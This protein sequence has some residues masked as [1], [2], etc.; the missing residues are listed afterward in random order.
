MVT[1]IVVEGPDGS[2]K[3]TLALWIAQKYGLE[4]TRPPADL[5][6]SS[7]GP[8]PGLVEWWENELGSSASKDRVYDRTFYVSEVLYA[9][10]QKDRPLMCPDPE[11]MTRGLADF[12]HRVDL[13]IFCL[14]GWQVERQNLDDVGRLS[15]QGVDQEQLEKISWAYEYMHY[16]FSELMFERCTVYDYT[17]MTLS[18]IEEAVSESLSVA[19]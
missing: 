8:S 18:H 11:R 4:Y 3:T 12:I 7:E 16:L 13:L 15:L 10:A 9:Q 6:S 5:L 19:N 2:G 14:P 1:I 17:T